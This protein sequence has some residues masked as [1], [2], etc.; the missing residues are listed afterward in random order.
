MTKQERTTKLF[1]RLAAPKV[2]IRRVPRPIIA[3]AA[4][5]NVRTPNIGIER[6]LKGGELSWTMDGN[7]TERMVQRALASARMLIIGCLALEAEERTLRAEQQS[8]LSAQL[9]ASIV[10][11]K[12]EKAAKAKFEKEEKEAGQ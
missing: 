8:D 4:A 9:E 2:P 12:E 7:V 1:K 11:T 6:K 3:L 5:P 10:R